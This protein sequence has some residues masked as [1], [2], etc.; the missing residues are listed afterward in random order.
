LIQKLLASKTAGLSDHGKQI[1]LVHA[2]DTATKRKTPLTEP[3][4][5]WLEKQTGQNQCMLDFIAI[6]KDPP[7]IVTDHLDKVIAMRE[8][9]VGLPSVVHACK[10]A[11]KGKVDLIK[12]LKDELDKIVSGL[13]PTNPVM[14]KS[15]IDKVKGIQDCIPLE[16]S[17]QEALDQCQERI[18]KSESKLAAVQSDLESKTDISDLLETLN[19]QVWWSEASKT[20]KR[21]LDLIVAAEAKLN[22]TLA[23]KS[24]IV[25]VLGLAFE[26]LTCWDM[27]YKQFGSQLGWWRYPDYRP[28]LKK[29]F[30]RFLRHLG[31][32][33]FETIKNFDSDSDDEA[34]E[35]L[36]VAV[37][38][39]RM[40]TTEPALFSGVFKS[41][42][43]S[44]LDVEKL[45]LEGLTNLM[46]SWTK[47]QGELA[48]GFDPVDF[49]YLLNVFD[50]LKADS[51]VFDHAIEVAERP[52]GIEEYAP[53]LKFLQTFKVGETYKQAKVSLAKVLND[54]EK[55]L[56]PNI[57]SFESKK[58]DTSE[59]TS[60]EAS[61]RDDFYAVCT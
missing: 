56:N 23:T 54:L 51:P 12:L 28:P 2:S 20:K 31:D 57:C 15:C 44:P 42:E 45:M 55:G 11:S 26:T 47:I 18:Q 9:G 10:A 19:G 48:D 13:S 58:R 16:S 59:L 40:K 24:G 25:N 50:S 38:L 37:I 32:C 8:D 22:H 36:E 21:I 14:A 1:Q 60:L 6:R 4:V 53:F 33:I 43:R 61:D 35:A 7:K 46:A 49:P 34:K 41:P 29:A 39:I 52:D 5:K 30:D 27:A 17:S 3:Q